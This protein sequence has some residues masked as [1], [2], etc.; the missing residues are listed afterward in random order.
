MSKISKERKATY[1]LGMG[2]GIL[3]FILFISVFFSFSS[4]ISDPDPFGG[5]PSFANAIVGMLLMIGGAVVA[6][7]GA[8]GA[9]GSGVI[10]DPEQAR[11]DL[12]PFNEARGG[13]I[14]DVISNIDAIDHITKP[15]STK[16]IVKIRCRNCNGLNDEDA[17]FCKSCGKEI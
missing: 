4:A 5:P 14:N 7:I 10:L 8:K 9:A 16:E 17:K 6:S 3:G 12:K 13:M 2:M 1:Y 11:E 15:Q